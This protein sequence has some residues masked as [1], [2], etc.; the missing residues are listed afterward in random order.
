MLTAIS[1]AGFT[2]EDRHRA[3]LA[4]TSGGDGIAFVMPVMAGKETAAGRAW[5]R[6]RSMRQASALVRH[7]HAIRAGPAVSI[8]L[9]IPK[10]ALEKC[11]AGFSFS[12]R[13]SAATLNLHQP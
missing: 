2:A 7:S 10:P 4:V 8:R 3:V 11:R 9:C 12:D 1:L 6:T 5:R 13:R